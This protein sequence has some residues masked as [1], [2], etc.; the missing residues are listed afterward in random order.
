VF[1]VIVCGAG[2]A[3]STAAT[4]LARGGARVLM[5]DRANFPRDKLCGDTV[6]PGTAVILRRLRLFGPIQAVASRVDGMIVTGEH[7]VSVRCA[8]DRDGCGYAVLRRDLD[9]SLARAAVAAGVRFEQGTVVRGP[10][11]DEDA[12]GPCVR[13][14]VLAGCDGRDLRVPAAMVVAADGRRSRLAIA[15]GLTRQPR[16]PRRWAVGAYFSGVADVSSFGEMHVRRGRYVGVA[17]VPSGLVNVCAVVPRGARLDQPASVLMQQIAR[18]P[19]L[20]ER[21]QSARL[22]SP[23]IVLGPL[24]VDAVDAGAP[25]LLLAGDAAGFIDPMTGDGLRFAVRGGELAGQ[26]ALAGFGGRLSSPHAELRR[27]RR[28]EFRAKWRFNRTLR[29]LVGRPAVVE[30]AGLAAFTAPWILQRAIR[31]AGDVA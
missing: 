21:F 29:Q 7:G 17:R 20:R 26:V 15:L 30:L 5:I 6:N 24:A 27:L 8:Y 1:D 11:L 18:D 23:P 28:R 16:R 2:P 3:G 31:Y 10:L 25:G 9:D 14:V 4:V 12:A 22:A 13:G 19:R